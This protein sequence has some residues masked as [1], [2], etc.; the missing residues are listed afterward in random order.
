[1]PVIEINHPLIKSNLTKLRDKKSSISEFRLSLTIISQFLVYESSKESELNTFNIETP[2]VK[3]LGYKIKNEIIFIPVLRAGLGML[4]G[5]LSVFDSAKVGHFGVKRN[6]VSLMPE[7]YYSNI[8]YIGENSEVYILDPMLATG[9]SILSLLDSLKI[10]NTAK[11]TIICIISS[12]EGIKNIQRKYKDIK[13]FT[14][15]IDEKLNEIGY[16]I[17]GLGDAGDRLFGTD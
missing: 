4:S 3:A 1:M 8:P 10:I 17:P 9:G 2:L 7:H 16:I 6:E 12:P 14:A 13:I 11:I 15:S 5:A